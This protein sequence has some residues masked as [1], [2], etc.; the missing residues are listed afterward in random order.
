MASLHTFHRHLFALLFIVFG[1][2]PTWAALPNALSTTVTTEQVRAELM[3]HAPDGV[4]PGKTVWVGLRLQHQP[5]WHTY[6][7]NAGDSGQPTTLS[8]TLPVG[9]LAGDI[10]WPIPKKLPIGNLANYGYDG[11]VLLPV[12][13]TVTPD[14]KPSA[15]NP[16]LEI[17]LQASW[18]VCKQEC[19]P[20]DGEFVLRLP[21]QGSTAMGAGAFAAAFEAQPRVLKGQSNIAIEGRSLKV[22]VSSLPAALQGK[23]LELF[24]EIAEVIE[25]AA[26]WTQTWQG[27]VWTAS[28]PIATHR[29]A[30]PHTLPLVLVAEV[31]GQ[32]S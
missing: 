12:P 10:A 28:V 18:L 27:A 14:F 25:T 13:L 7:K 32:R 23:T 3:A 8:W 21:V 26:P 9:V 1:T 31:G 17:K 30:S 29:S 19:V 4:G 16:E 15:L 24:P 5:E 11:T 22:S 6:W 2:V 20:Q